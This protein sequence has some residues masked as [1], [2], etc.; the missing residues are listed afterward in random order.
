MGVSKGSYISFGRGVTIPMFEARL[1]SSRLRAKKPLAARDRVNRIV[2]AAAV[3][4]V[5]S[6]YST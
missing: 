3:V 5:A 2:A 6:I 1:N 4:V